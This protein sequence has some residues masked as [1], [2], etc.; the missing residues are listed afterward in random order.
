MTFADKIISFLSIIALFFSSL[1]SLFGGTSVAEIN[2][3][4]STT[5]DIVPNIVDNINLWD[6]G[7][8]F[9]EPTVNEEY[10]IYD[11]VKYV[12]LMQCTG[13]TAERDLFKD[14]LDTTTMTDYDFSHLI[15]NCEGIL[16]L[17][18]KPHLKLGG[19]PLKFTN[20]Y[21]MGGFGMNVYP[22]DDYNDYYNYINAI[23][24]ELVNEFGLEEVKTW[25]FGCMTEFENGDWF[26]AKIQT[27][28]K[29]ELA[30]ATA[31]EYCKLY[32]YTVKALT[33]VLGDDI[34]VGAH[35][36]VVTEGLWDEEIFIKHVAEGKNYATG[37]KGT[38]IKFLA[39][40]FYDTKPGKF[41]DGKTLPK[42]VAALKETAE[43]YGLTDLFYGVD[44][45]RILEGNAKGKND[46]QLLT[47]ICGDTW[48]AAYDA[49]LYTQGIK[50]GL[51]YFSAWGY[52]SNGLSDGN[53][54]V[55]YHVANNIADF[56]GSS[57]AE[58]TV[59]AVKTSL[60]V[61]VDC[62]AAWDFDTGTLRIMVYNFKNDVD[63][64][65]KLKINLDLTVPQLDGK[66]VIITKNVISDDCNY[67]DEWLKDR[68]QYNITDDCFSWSPDD[69]A[70]DSTGVLAD[71]N[72]RNIYFNELKSKYYECSKLIPDISYECV[73]NSKLEITDTIGASNVVF[74]EITV[75]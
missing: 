65:K 43:K 24:K 61:D 64:S 72:A 75:G 41:T 54:T 45:G 28:S 48:Q 36:M 1:T 7:T 57:L 55:S 35:G 33:D 19:V 23:A 32:D 63:Y 16:S 17:G 66:E 10:N 14:P 74:Y 68:E 34:C 62:L 52:L 50:S 58:T 4:T 31:E 9:F 12:Q 49:R 53:P 5:G 25:R 27:E 51:D 39:A 2:I 70:I 21:E 11:F 37:Q 30:A 18:A 42:T 73:E 60:K 40:S 69:P 20:G 29:E 56:A 59:K 71:E 22:P 13:G 15:K 47:R 67:F 3:D 44:E 6:M 8:Q 46:T 26:K 38:L